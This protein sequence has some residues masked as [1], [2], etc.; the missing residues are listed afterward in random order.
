MSQVTHDF[1]GPQLVRNQSTRLLVQNRCCSTHPR[2]EPGSCF[3]HFIERG[4]PRFDGSLLAARG[5]TLRGTSSCPP[6]S[7]PPLSN[8]AGR[9]TLWC[10][11]VPALVRSWVV[12]QRSSELTLLLHAGKTATAEALAQA[13][14]D[15]PIAVVTYS[16][17][18]Q[19]D[20]EQRLKQ[21]PY[22]Q[23]FTFHSL[24]SRLFRELVHNDSL[25]RGLREQ[26]APPVWRM[27]HYKYVAA[28]LQSAT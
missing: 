23:A 13:N 11:L 2:A 8:D 28:T 16:K 27:P 6:G 18:L 5:R 24:A 10:L 12:A 21:Y 4:L 22:A 19:I 14:P 3:V 17:R 20:T 9:R 7:K 26:S 25:L 1:C 15:V